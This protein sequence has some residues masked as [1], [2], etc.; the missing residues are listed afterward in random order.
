MEIGVSYVYIYSPFL[1]PDGS[2]KGRLCFHFEVRHHQVTIQCRQIDY[3]TQIPSLLR[4]LEQQA[5][6]PERCFV[7]Y[8]LYGSFRQQGIHGLL[9][10]LGAVP[11]A[12]LDGPTADWSWN[13]SV[14]PVGSAR[15]AGCC[16]DGPSMCAGPALS[17]VAGQQGCSSRVNSGP[18]PSL[19]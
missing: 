19:P 5:V 13:G 16:R 3:G 6:E 7:Q 15:A 14:T 17:A 11:G 1:A 12:E 8:P 2:S 10:I 4:H 18:L 9:E